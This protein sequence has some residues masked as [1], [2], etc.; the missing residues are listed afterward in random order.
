MEA[1]AETLGRSWAC[2]PLQGDL[3]LTRPVKFHQ[4]HVLVLPQNQASVLDRHHHLVPQQEGLQ[5]GMGE[6]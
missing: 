3:A 1:G 2:Q 4:D 5:V 6:L